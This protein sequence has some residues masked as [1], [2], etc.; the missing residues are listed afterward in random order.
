MLI[1]YLEIWRSEAFQGEDTIKER[2]L[3]LGLPLGV[4]RVPQA[5]VAPAV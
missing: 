2:G 5:K 1:D 3:C 4:A